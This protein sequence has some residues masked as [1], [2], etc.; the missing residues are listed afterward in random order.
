ML[1]KVFVH[2]ISQTVSFQLQYGGG[3]VIG[4]SGAPGGGAQQ[5]QQLTHQQVLNAYA[6]Q[7]PN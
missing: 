4:S 6:T 2:H 5:P 3:M 7:H 1:N